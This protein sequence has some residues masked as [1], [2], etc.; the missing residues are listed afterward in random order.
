MFETVLQKKQPQRHLSRSP[1]SSK[2]GVCRHEYPSFVNNDS[3]LLPLSCW[4]VLRALY[5]S[6]YLLVRGCHHSLFSRGASGS[7]IVLCISRVSRAG[8][9][10]AMLCA[11]YNIIKSGSINPN[12]VLPL[13][14]L[15]SRTSDLLRSSQSSYSQTYKSLT[16]LRILLVATDH[17]TPGPWNIG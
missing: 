7:S 10:F 5:T 14:H 15:T 9:S 6:V 8:S 13:P 11:V 3:V 12:I 17:P 4:S 1:L 2:P 16:C